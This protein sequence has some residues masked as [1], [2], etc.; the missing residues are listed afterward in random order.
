MTYYPHDV[1]RTMSM[2]LITKDSP[3]NIVEDLANPADIIEVFFSIWLL[4][5]TSRLVCVAP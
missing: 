1:A 4:L 2:S 5:V 3:G